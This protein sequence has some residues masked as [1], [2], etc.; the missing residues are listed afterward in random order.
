MLL[1][2]FTFMAGE[3]TQCSSNFLLDNK[4]L[5]LLEILVMDILVRPGEPGFDNPDQFGPL[6]NISTYILKYLI[7]YLTN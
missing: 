6:S 2:M 3:L 4:Q 1:L 5:F 7:R